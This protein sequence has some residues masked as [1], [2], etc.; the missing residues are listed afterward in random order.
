VSPMI[1]QDWERYRRAFDGQPLPAALVDL[2]AFE[3]NADRLLEIARRGGKTLRLATKSI[4]CP[5]LVQRALERGKGAARGLMTYSAAETAFLAGQGFD[6]LLLAYPTVQRS[7]VDEM[8]RL[9]REGKLV[10]VAADG[11][12]Q[13]E[14]YEQAAVRAG[15]TLRVTIDVDVAYR[16][17]GGPHLG[18]RR[19]PL[20][21][22]EDVLQFTEAVAKRPHLRLD[23]LLTYEA[24]IAG[25]PDRSPFARWTN[26]AMR[27]MKLAARRQL[28]AIRAE[29]ARALRARSISLRLC[30]GGGTGSLAWAAADPSLTEVTAGSGLLDSQLFDYYRDLQ[31][32]PAAFFALQIT[33]KPREDLAVCQGGGWV[34]SGAAGP[35]RLPAP[36]LPAGC[37]LLPME[38]AGEVQT[39]VLLPPGV[40][41]AIGDPIFFRHAKAGELA[42][43]V[44]EYLLVRGDKLEGH[45]PTYR[46]LGKCFG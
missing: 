46:G 40:R 39:P 18:V 16:P 19:S 36:A 27:L 35:D 42:E 21:T 20:R 25:V 28:E 2:A 31:L 1:D 12:E 23:G 34:A 38:G 24:Q 29:L 33:R 8:A 26:G 4:R 22:V 13:L 7:D 14:A 9:A 45:A 5:A 11:P 10:T 30:N 3:A 17:L 32:S 43:H 6:D 44:V 41:P 37:R 15:T